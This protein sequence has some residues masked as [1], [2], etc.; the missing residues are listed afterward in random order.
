[1]SSLAP[2]KTFT[3]LQPTYAIDDVD[4]M[5]KAFH[6]DGF[7]LVPGVLSLAEVSS[8]RASIDALK[9]IGFDHNSGPNHHFKN[10]FNQNPAFLAMI[11]R[12]PAVNVAERTHTT[13]CHIIGQTAWR[14]Y[15]GH[16]GWGVH[17]D[18][19]MLDLPEDVFGRPGFTLPGY[20][21]T[22]HYYL[23][24]I[25]DT[26]LCPT[27]VVPGSHKSGRGP[28]P[29]ETSFR[30]KE[31]QPV[32]VKAGDMLF[33]RG[34]VWHTGSKNKTADQVRYLLQVHYSRRNFAQHFSPFLSWQFNPEV[35]KIASA[36]QLRL[37]GN[38]PPGAYD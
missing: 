19:L 6:E 18:Q 36:R 24:D 23:S 22:A 10:V 16:D 29:G 25:L 5:V 37:L 2:E 7:A 4:G 33:F 14:S 12:A 32:L 30:G 11:D 8:L 20:V 38:H 3:Y 28:K 26:D 35:L 13:D 9:P 27:Y 15:P 34:E 31:L 1:M 17:V 21:S